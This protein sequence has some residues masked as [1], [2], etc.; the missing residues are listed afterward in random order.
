MVVAI[1]FSPWLLTIV[2]V[3]LGLVFMIGDSVFFHRWYQEDVIKHSSHPT[4]VTRSTLFLAAYVP[5]SI[6]IIT[7]S[8]SWIGRSL[9]ATIG[10]VI[11]WEMFVRRHNV[12]EFAQHFSVTQHT[13]LT[14]R[15]VQRLTWLALALSALWWGVIVLTLWQVA[16]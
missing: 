16:S 6:F 5:L 9:I 13:L 12:E 11:A 10:V 1:L 14:Q 7:S 8:G 15:Y 2:G 4:L 3:V